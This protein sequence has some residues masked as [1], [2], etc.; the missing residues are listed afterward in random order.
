MTMRL[1]AAALAALLFVPLSAMAQSPAAAPATA[2][3]GKSGGPLEACRADVDTLCGSA[4]KMPGWRG[5][6]LRENTAMLSD[7]CKTT[8]SGFGDGEKSRSSNRMPARGGRYFRP[9]S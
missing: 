2:A 7:G 6:C 4:E 8:M 5:K 3:Q 1:G 9:G